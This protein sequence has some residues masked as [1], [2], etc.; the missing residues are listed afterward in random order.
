MTDSAADAAVA[1]LP[2]SPVEDLSFEASL[3][4]A[5][6]Q[7]DM[8]QETEETKTEDTP[9]QTQPTSN[10]E[11]LDKPEETTDP[12]EQLSDDV[13]NDWTP[14][15]AKRFKQLK[16]ELKDYK[17][18]LQ[19]LQ[20]AK[21]Q[22]ETQ[23]EELKGLADSK[24]AEELRQKLEDYEKRQMFVDL[25]QTTAYQKAVAEPLRDLLGQA[26]QIAEKYDVDNSDLI[27]VLSMN[28][29]E[30]Q[31]ERLAELLPRASDRDKAKI[32]NILERIDPLVQRREEMMKNTEQALAEAKLVEEQQQRAELAERARLR[33][34][35]TE[36]VVE[37]IQQ[38][39]PFLTKLEGLDLNKIKQDASSIDP[40]T[41]HAVDHMFNAVSAK[42]FPSI[43]REYVSL[44][45]EFDSITDRL[46]EYE[47]AE[48]KMS[49]SSNTSKASQAAGS[50]IDRVNSAFSGL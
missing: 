43:V 25:E 45:K 13:G 10:T 26:A 40:T 48:P 35:V 20:Q 23:I 31:E 14:E 27:D 29:A 15:A 50:F 11:E 18:Q 32:Y 8:P 6:A 46:A 21:T 49:G 33:A 12:I 36:N 47:Q 37:R 30:L 3:E 34:T 16:Q 7:L 22:Y 5:F 17:S 38:K 28:D 1:E 44:K 2:D 4:R 41:L 42:L 39:L 9:E 24:E 19:E